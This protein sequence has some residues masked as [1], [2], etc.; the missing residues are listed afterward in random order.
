MKKMALFSAMGLALVLAAGCSS[1][2]APRLPPG[3][4]KEPRTEKPPVGAFN[5]TAAPAVQVALLG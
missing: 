4:D 2:T 3:E 5:D 1:P